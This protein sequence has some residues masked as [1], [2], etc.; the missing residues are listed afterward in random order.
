MLVQTRKIVD[1][2]IIILHNC[3]G[4]PCPIRSRG[5]ASKEHQ[6]S[7]IATIVSIL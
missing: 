3:R 7:V 1:Y 4:Q 6:N 2:N 5:S